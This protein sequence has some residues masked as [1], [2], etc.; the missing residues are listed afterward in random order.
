MTS[1]RVFS[2]PPSSVENGSRSLSAAT[3]TLQVSADF[4][5]TDTLVALPPSLEL[6]HSVA[7]FRFRLAAVAF[8]RDFCTSRTARMFVV[9]LVGDAGA[10]GTLSLPSL[11]DA[12]SATPPGPTFFGIAFATRR[13]QCRRRDGSFCRRRCQ[14]SRPSGSLD[15]YQ[16]ACLS[17]NYETSD[18][19]GMVT[20]SRIFSQLGTPTRNFGGSGGRR[21]RVRGCWHAYLRA[22]SAAATSS[23]SMK[24]KD[25]RVEPGSTWIECHR[26]RQASMRKTRATPS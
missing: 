22:R 14:H 16:R 1:T 5:S 24:P 17:G 25:H 20:F 2:W 10:L 11:F 19:A 3:S 4:F 21:F 15:A 7:E 6:A 9:T 8:V 18:G 26:R 23:G 13:L 12:S